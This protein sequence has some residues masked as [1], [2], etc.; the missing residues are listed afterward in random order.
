MLLHMLPKNVLIVAAA[1][2]DGNNSDQIENYPND[3]IGTGEEVS[4]PF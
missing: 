2:N 1:G 3:Q 4:M